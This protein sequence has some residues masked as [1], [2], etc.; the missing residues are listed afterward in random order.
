MSIKLQ[1][2]QNTQ[3]TKT[4]LRKDCQSWMAFDVKWLRE[5]DPPCPWVRGRVWWLLAEDIWKY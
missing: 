4:N 2:L 1:K 3:N 5:Q